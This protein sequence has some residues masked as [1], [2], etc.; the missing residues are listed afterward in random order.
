MHEARSVDALVGRSRTEPA[1][2]LTLVVLTHAPERAL[3]DELEDR[4]R[5]G[6]PELADL[7]D[8]VGE[9]QLLIDDRVVEA[10]DHHGPV[11]ADLPV[12]DPAVPA[13][14]AVDD[15]PVAQTMDDAHLQDRG[16]PGDDLR[17]PRRG[18]AEEVVSSMTMPAT[19]C[20]YLAAR[21]PATWASTSSPRMAAAMR[22]ITALLPSPTDPRVRTTGGSGTDR[23]PGSR[24]RGQRRHD[25]RIERLT[26]L[27]LP[28]ALRRATD[29]VRVCAAA[30]G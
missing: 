19:C 17:H 16:E 2:V 11:A 25:R 28:A 26:G 10:S 30:P 15:E 23:A 13:Q 4:D 18:Y 5:V 21:Y 12:G 6:K 29:P 9:P 20:G 8:V 3:R 1:Q 7:V 14:E 27:H 24:P 22:P